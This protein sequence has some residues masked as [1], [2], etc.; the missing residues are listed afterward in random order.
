VCTGR[1]GQTHSAATSFGGGT[2]GPQPNPLYISIFHIFSS[3]T[4]INNYRHATC[5]RKEICGGY[6]AR[7]SLILGR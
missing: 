7:S 4:C 5:D 6:R 1:G 3:Q 2:T